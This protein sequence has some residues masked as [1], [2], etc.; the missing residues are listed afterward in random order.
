MAELFNCDRELTAVIQTTANP[1]YDI[2]ATLFFDFIDSYNL[3]M[4]N[5]PHSKNT[6]DA[7]KITDHVSRNQDIL[8]LTGT[9]GC[10][11]GCGSQG[12]DE[13]F[14]VE[15]QVKYFKERL[16][17]NTKSFAIITL[18]TG[19]IF[20]RG[21]LVNST[22]SLNRNKPQEKS[23]SLTFHGYNLSGSVFKPGIAAGGVFAKDLGF[24]II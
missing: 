23:V 21:V 16:L 13:F 9:I 11:H 1:S 22:I 18:S 15:E 6:S 2:W 24:P 19:F 17:H 8:T 14:D 3:Q 12:S 4:S 5:T 7:W 20:R 10:R